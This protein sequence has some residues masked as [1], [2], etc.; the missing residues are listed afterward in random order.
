MKNL[1]KRIKFDFRMFLGSYPNLFFPI[2][3]LKKVN[4][5]LFINNKTQL[6][7]S[8]FPRTANTFFIVALESVQKEKIEIAHHLHV[9]ALALE[10]IKK[11]IPTVLLIRNP[12]DSIISLL[13]REN[14]LTLEQ[15]INAYISFYKPMLKYKREI[16]I[17]DFHTIIN[18]FT[19]IIESI[20]KKFKLNLTNYDEDNKLDNDEIFAKI[21]KINKHFNKNTLVETKVSRPS[22]NRSELKLKLQKKLEEKKYLSRISLCEKLYKEL[23]N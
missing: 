5:N 19:S 1:I 2:Y 4:K 3:G 6:V 16:L 10:G 7:I 20:N 21:D 11:N 23:V 18:D 9:P 13:I 17:F 15:A 22:T 8:A 12:K 14:H